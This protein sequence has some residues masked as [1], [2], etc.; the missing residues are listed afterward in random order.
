MREE[1]GERNQNNE[2]EMKSPTASPSARRKGLGLRPRASARP[3]PGQPGCGAG[4]VFQKPMREGHPDEQDKHHSRTENRGGKSQPRAARPLSGSHRPDHRR[5]GSRHAAL[6]QAVGPRQG[7]RPGDAAQ[8]GDRSALSR[9]QRADARHVGPG[10][11]QRRSA[12]GDLQAGGRPGL[13]G[14]QGRARHDRVFL[15]AA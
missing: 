10:L 1:T 7:R 5:A 4:G 14:S 12:L 2:N 3:C 9:H 13:A 11:Q 6:A 15:Q 8:R